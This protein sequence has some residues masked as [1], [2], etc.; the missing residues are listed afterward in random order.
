MAEWRRPWRQILAASVVLASAGQAAGP[1][2]FDFAEV[3]ASIAYLEDPS[4]EQLRAVAD[5]DA[6]RH[7]ARH[8]ERTGY[9]PAE[10]TRLDIA[11]AL[12]RDP[13]RRRS[14]DA[15]KALVERVERDAAGQQLCL[16]EPLR[17]G[18]PGAEIRG[19]VYV[20]WGYDIGVAEGAD[21]SLN[22]AHPRFLEQPSEVW[23]YCIHEVHHT[24]VMVVHPLPRLSDVKTGRQLLELVRYL[25]YLEGTAVYAAYDAR[26]RGGALADDPDYVALQDRTTM[27]RLENTYLELYHRIEAL[28]DRTVTDGDW[29]L[30]EQ[31][32]NGDR[33][34]YRVG[35]KMAESI[36]AVEGR[37]AFRE[38]VAGGPDAFFEHARRVGALHGGGGTEP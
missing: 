35:A 3:R 33:L 38:V 8:S 17:Y 22:L 29:A 34:W 10:A 1:E 11:E 14:L 7:L 12:I 28:G 18:P 25:T 15:V 23:Y 6:M 27:Q 36:D 30:L 21:A 2:V 32:S 19:H 9:Y 26:S 13:A 37:E 31:F 24:L 16:S 5:T 20:T 4:P